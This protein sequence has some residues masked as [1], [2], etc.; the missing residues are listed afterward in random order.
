MY[1][2]NWRA[3]WFYIKI[4]FPLS[5]KRTKWTYATY[6]DLRNCNHYEYLFQ[7]HLRGE[8]DIIDSPSYCMI[9]SILCSHTQDK[10]SAFVLITWC[11]NIRFLINKFGKKTSASLCS[12]IINVFTRGVHSC[13]WLNFS[14][15]LHFDKE[16]KGMNL[17]MTTW[18]GSN[19]TK[20]PTSANTI[21]WRRVYQKMFG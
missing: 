14:K 18:C 17:K 13:G 7:A 15:L 8:W 10:K 2:L 3:P 19:V 1:K 12:E 5:P 9:M 16:G 4:L 21:G 11:L 20:L 6:A